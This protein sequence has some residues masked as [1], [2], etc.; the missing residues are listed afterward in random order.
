MMP[1]V[2]TLIQKIRN[3]HWQFRNSQTNPIY[4]NHLVRLCKR[5]S[6]FITIIN[7]ALNSSDNNWDTELINRVIKYVLD[8]GNA[9]ISVYRSDTLDPLDCGHG[10]AVVAEGISQDDFQIDRGKKRKSSC[11]RGSLIIPTA[12]LP[13]TTS[14]E[15]TPQNNLN[16][17]PANDRHFDLTIDNTEEF[18]ISLLNGINKRTIAW[19]LLGND[20]PYEGSY[21]LQASI[22]YSNC[23]QTF[24]KLNASDPPSVWTDGEKLTASEQIDILRYLAQTHIV[25]SPS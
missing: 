17:Y 1:L 16:F 25:D 10:L 24:G 11:T 15:F 3:I 22:A 9:G 12:Y 5:R 4:P 2:S 13:Q 20:K 7:E 21:R 14:Y 19:S 23:L 6:E 8:G 18:A